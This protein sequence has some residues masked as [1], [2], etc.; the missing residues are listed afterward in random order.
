MILSADDPHVVKWC[1]DA[2]FAVHPDFQEPHW[3]S[4]ASTEAELVGTDVVSPV[5]TLWTNLFMEAQ[6]FEIKKNIL[7]QDN[8]SA[9]LL[10]NNGE[11]GSSKGT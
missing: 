6:G 9:V 8:K 11:R 7:Y 1:V 5:M 10:E 3:W 4:A 2:S